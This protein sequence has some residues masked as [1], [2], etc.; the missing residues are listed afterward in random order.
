MIRKIQSMAA[1]LLVAGLL[2]A[3]PVAHAQSD[4]ADHRTPAEEAMM[5]FTIPEQMQVEH[6]EL[7]ATLARLTKESGRTGEAAKA[8]ARVLEPH[9]AKEN[10]YALPPLSLLLPLSQG[11]FEPKMVEILKLTDRL[12]AEMPAMLAEHENITAALKKLHD[13]ATSE[14][15]DTGIHFAEH[16]TAHAH[17]EEEFTY[18]AALLIGKYVKLRA[19]QNVR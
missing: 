7:H 3:G 4:P 18:P 6:E 19:A 17:E 9:F 5:S 2:C 13:A 15:N 8:V 11:K 14:H 1:A 12:E 10:E 16:L